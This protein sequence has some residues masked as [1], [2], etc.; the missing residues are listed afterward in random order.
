MVVDVHI[1]APFLRL[2]GNRADVAV[3]GDTVAELL[4]NLEYRYPGFRGML[5]ERGCVPPHKI[6]KRSAG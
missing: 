6:Y 1:P 2:T 4:D 5:F 3:Q